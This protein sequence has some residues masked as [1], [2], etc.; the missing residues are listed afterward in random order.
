M[1]RSTEVW[2]AA[3]T[4]SG[5][6]PSRMRAWMS[7]GRSTLSIHNT[8]GHVRRLHR[9]PPE[10]RGLDADTVLQRPRGSAQHTLQVVVAEDP[11]GVQLVPEGEEVGE[12]R[13]RRG[14]VGGGAGVQLAP[15]RAPVVRAEDLL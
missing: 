12:A 14:Q 9:P 5:L 4:S 15:V 13:V 6:S 3:A 11:V 8:W 7:R 2:A 1:M 10:R